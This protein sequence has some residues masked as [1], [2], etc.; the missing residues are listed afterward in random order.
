MATTASQNVQQTPF[1]KQLA[2][3]GPSRTPLY[4]NA[5]LTATHADRPTRDAAVASLKTYLTA[6]RTFTK[7]DLLKLWKGLFYCEF[8]S[9]PLF[10]SSTLKAREPGLRRLR[11]FADGQYAGFW[12]SDRPRVQQA[13][14]NDLAELLI[15]MS[16]SN[17]PTFFRAFWETMTREWSGIDALRIDKFLL[18]VRRYLN[19]GFRYC[20]A[21]GWKDEIV[22]TLLLRPLETG[23]LDP[24]N[25]R[26][27]NGVRF[28][29]A[30]VWVEELEKVQ[31][32]KEI[33]V[34]L[35]VRP[36]E[37]MARDGAQ[38][39]WRIKA[40]EVLGEQKWVEW[41]YEGE[42]AAGP[43]QR[44]DEGAE[45]EEWGGFDD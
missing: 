42:F 32:G 11:T 35:L 41:G 19:A 34:A 10:S 37:T 16:E 15:P 1:V 40:K 45:E 28:Q 18:L 36:W 24:T 7:T 29:L 23:P 14:A 38:K 39:T 13:L 9:S 6:S 5:Q 31:G 2:A 22:E 3:N 21:R 25:Q 27:P 26:M 12:L 20:A 4:L 44:K 30:D 8:P 17:A 43:E 33:H